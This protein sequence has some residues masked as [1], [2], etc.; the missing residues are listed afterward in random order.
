MAFVTAKVELLRPT[1][2]AR[3]RRVTLECEAGGAL[4][5][6][7]FEADP[8]PGAAFGFTDE[9]LAHSIAP[10]DVPR[11][12]LAA[13]RALLGARDDAVERFKAI[14]EENEIPIRT[15]RWT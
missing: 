3:Y 11:F 5:V 2:G 8:S 7:S 10:E 6:R 1:V 12:A 4:V 13:V 9:E 14:C 15:T